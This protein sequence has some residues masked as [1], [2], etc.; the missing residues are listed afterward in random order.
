MTSDYEHLLGISLQ[1]LRVRDNSKTKKQKKKEKKII[2]HGHVQM[3]EPVER[4]SKQRRLQLPHL[5]GSVIELS[6]NTE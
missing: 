1:S 5:M 2:R 4:S 3:R 6:L